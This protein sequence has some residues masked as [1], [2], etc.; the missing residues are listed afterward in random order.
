[1]AR[2]V[3]C[4]EP[5]V[6]VA[7]LIVSIALATALAVSAARKLTHAPDVVA[8]YARAGVP[9]ARL[10]Q[11]AA[12]LFAS[13]AGLLVG[14]WWS[15]WASPRQWASPATSSSRSPSTS[16]RAIW[17][18]CPC[19]SRSLVWLR[20]RPPFGSRRH[21]HQSAC[22]VGHQGCPT[23]GQSDYAGCA[24]ASRQHLSPIRSETRCTRQRSE[25]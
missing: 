18:T 22:P 19:P 21:D 15:P 1:V 14:L 24:A 3:C 23:V 10:N 13:A 2:V 9:A 12:V 25:R 20:S 6:F 5:P 11:L 8:G 16:G 17:P 4:R 7:A